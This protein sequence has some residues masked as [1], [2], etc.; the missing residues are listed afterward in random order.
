MDE[1][2]QA[3]PTKDN[4]EKG[5][6]EDPTLP[7]EKDS[8]EEDLFKE[9]TGSDPA[10]DE[11]PELPEDEESPEITVN[12]KI[13]E[14]P[15]QSEG[16]ENTDSSLENNIDGNIERSSLFEDSE[17]EYS[18]KDDDLFSGIEISSD[19]YDAKTD[20]FDDNYNDPDSVEKKEAGDSYS[21]FDDISEFESFA[22]EEKK[23]D[24][25]SS[26]DLFEDDPDLFSPQT[27]KDGKDS[28]DDFVKNVF[29][30]DEESDNSENIEGTIYF[31]KKDSGEIVGPFRE[32][33]LEDL[34]LKGVISPEDDISHDGFSW[35]SS[36]AG[37]EETSGSEEFS[38]PEGSSESDM[39][40]FHGVG[41]EDSIPFK[42]NLSVKSENEEG[43]T[44]D[45]GLFSD[46]VP[47]EFEGTSMTG[48]GNVSGP[49]DHVF[50]PEE[51]TDSE[52]E[53]TGSLRSKKRKI[54]G[55]VPFFAVLAVSTIILL[56][57][58]GGGVYYYIN[59]MAGT[60]G[61]VLDK[62]SE[63]IAVHTGTLL[64]VREALNRD[65]PQ[66]Y[67]KSIGILRQYIK[68]GE[69]AP[70]PVGLDG[71]VKFNMIVSYDRRIEPVNVTTDKIV[72]E[73][74]H[75]PNNLDLI[76]A[77]ALSHYIQRNFDE[78]IRILQPFINSD[79]PEV[80]YILGL[81][82]TGKN[83]LKNAEN[84]FNTGFV[85]SKGRSAKI[86]YALADMKYRNG[87][88][89]SAIAFLNR[90]ISENPS[91]LRAHLLKGQILMNNPDRVKEAEE[92]L[93]G[94]DTGI[95]SVA[96]DF[97]KAEYFQM[98]AQA[99]HRRGDIR[100]AIANYEKAVEINK[101]DTSA[102][103]TIA[104]FYVQTG[105]SSK[106]M[107]YY[108][109][110]LNIDAK[111]PPAILGK[112]EIFTR[113]GQRDR[114]YLELAKLDLASIKDGGL[115]LRLGNIYYELGDQ[116]K[117]LEFYDKA[118]SASPSMIEPYLAKATV[119]L[120]FNRIDELKDISEKI[121][122][123][124]KE[125]YAYNLVRA[126]ILHQE[127]NFNNAE[128]FYKNAIERNVKGDE[129]VYH[130]YGTLLYD[131]HKYSE[132]SRNLERAYNVSPGNYRYLQAYIEALEKEGRW[133]DVIS[134][135][136]D[137]DFRERHMFRS[138][139]SLS[140][141]FLALKEYDEALKYIDRAIELNSGNSFLHYKKSK[142]LYSMAKYTEAESEI[143][144]AV[145]LEMRNFDNHMMY[146]RILIKRNDFKGAIEK[147]NAAEKIDPKNQT[148]MLLKGIVY[149]N[150]DDYRSAL[151]YFR[152]VTSPELRKE[153]Y[154]EI[155]ECFLHVNNIKEALKYFKMAERSG[156]P[157]AHRYL[158]RIYY[159]RGEM[160]TAVAYYRKSLRADKDDIQALRQLAFIYKE[161]KNYRR[162]LSYFRRYLNLIKD[163]SERKMIEDEI[164]FLN[165]NLTEAEK[166][167]VREDGTIEDDDEELNER[168]KEL[169]LEGRALRIEDPQLARERFRE[170]MRI[171]PKDNEYYKRA[172]RSLNRLQ[173]ENQ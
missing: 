140:N 170:V 51:L 93:R 37:A 8:E 70:S 68:P 112:S 108:D 99:A 123:L 100:E 98:I 167:S 107:E 124:G 71:Q 41:D 160:D 103:A 11:K 48:I 89:Q 62:I 171:V 120:E 67:I 52:M 39:E 155:G 13:G 109:M 84:F 157:N 91:Y 154:L 110:A 149:K 26:S 153:A 79:D 47:S 172:S 36:A 55:G 30:P 32:D 5:L 162:S 27:E 64:D 80:F 164:F 113:I 57:M 63:S 144:R 28:T 151:Q 106:A 73:L 121:G 86:T 4:G 168:A 148:L 152:R 3:G 74:S 117:A 166:A 29:E 169:Y 97:Q 75:A 19:R 95:I 85:H 1:V 96:E 146:A 90:V 17:S 114:V 76:K 81:C 136:E 119:L 139:V 20:F 24:D 12:H 150:L 14:S 72:E 46:A 158:A 10:E 116:G 138:Y 129:R 2:S 25:V 50:I 173:R 61:D 118:I 65:L 7:F 92:F 15:D 6:H 31:K 102:L 105:N 77:R 43:D 163:P 142:V 42:S 145:S 94:I 56:G 49:V 60:R 16:S 104:D 38:E 44:S 133:K 53:K 132:A 78:G 58:I 137:G 82:A 35:E 83:D 101:T 23:G 115:L 125:T 34:M 143:S 69:R 87:D 18:P 33:Q 134:L 122:V 21:K 45:T 59:Y 161:K 66:D 9:E 111:Y 22:E 127:G 156:N 126:I 128:V 135:L 165:R 40:I 54:G 131:Q 147:I 159:E 130:Y 88:S 141:A